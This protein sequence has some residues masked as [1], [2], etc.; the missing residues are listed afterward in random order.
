MT[1]DPAPFALEVKLQNGLFIAEQQDKATDHFFSVLKNKTKGLDLHN[2]FHY[3]W[4]KNKKKNAHSVI[5]K[6]SIGNSFPA[7]QSTLINFFS[8]VQE[9]HADTVYEKQDGKLKH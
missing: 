9:I 5:I 8:T 7:T 2:N 1:S 4:K 3:R 6:P